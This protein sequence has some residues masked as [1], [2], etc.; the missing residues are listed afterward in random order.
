[1]IALRGMHAALRPAAEYTFELA[2]YYGI[3]PR[4]TS[5]YRSWADQRRLRAR[6]EAGESRWPANVPG[7]SAHNFGWAFDS[8]VPEPQQATWDAIRRWVG[9]RVPES[10][11]I[12]A[13]LPD[14]RAYRPDNIPGNTR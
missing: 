4:V 8:V 10:D 13:E 7:D 2:H 5:T 6:W 11:Y 12:H 14:W 3:E 9:W 1:M